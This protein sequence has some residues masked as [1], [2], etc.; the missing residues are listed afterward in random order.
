MCCHINEFLLNG[1]C[2]DCLTFQ[3][4][5]QNSIIKKMTSSLQAAVLKKNITIS[6]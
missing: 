6:R 5:W 1:K 4:Q 2:S 3:D